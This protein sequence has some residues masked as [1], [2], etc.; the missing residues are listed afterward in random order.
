M[1]NFVKL[2]KNRNFSFLWFGQFVSSLGDRFTQMALLTIVM[3]LYAD[4]GEKMAWITFYS[5]LPFLFFG[6]VFGI[7]G[8]KLSRKRIMIIADI[9]R[10]VL[11]MMIPFLN[12]YAHSLGYIYL[13]IFCVGT[14][15]ALFSPA[16]MAIIPNLVEK[17]KVVSANSLVASSGMIATLIGTLLAGYLIKFFGPYPMFFMNAFT[18]F[19]SAIM[20]ANIVIQPREQKEEISSVSINSII[21]GIKDGFSFINRHQLILRIVQLNAVF[22]LISAFFYINVLN[23]ATTQ[24]NLFSQGYGIL[25]SFLGLGLCLGAVLLGRRIGKLNYNSLLFMGFGTIS[26]ASVLMMFKPDFKFS[27][28]ILILAGAGA[29]LVMI[30][31]DS[32]LQRATPDSLRANVFGARGIVTNFVF[33][34]IGNEDSKVTQTSIIKLEQSFILFLHSI[35]LYLIPSI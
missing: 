32:L 7:L 34:N 14:L 16:K 1:K 12:R 8:D 24:L 31:L 18:F 2:F 15:S 9:L 20:I 35:S 3:I 21:K 29:S 22:S 30:T 6:Q 13:I 25:L 19:I 4:T 33:G 28:L 17:E 27:I 5:L 26:L 10:A 23:Y 11:V